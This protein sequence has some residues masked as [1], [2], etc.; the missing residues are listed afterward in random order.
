MRFG[1]GMM[2]FSGAHRLIKRADLGTL[3]REL[4]G[5]LDPNLSNKLSWNLLMLVALEGNTNIGELLISRGASL[6]ATNDFG[7]TALSLAAGN[8]HT[9]FVQLLLANGAP[10]NCR[11]HGHSLA[12]W[13]RVASGL[14]VDKID[15]VLELIG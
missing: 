6:E 9:R 15:A 5:G 3:R 7:E 13:I 1:E 8:G 4:D 14:P 11:P 10:R 2:T 12:D